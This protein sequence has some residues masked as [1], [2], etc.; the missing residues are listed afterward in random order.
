MSNLLLDNSRGTTGGYGS[1][2]TG[3]S[4]GYDSTGTGLGS[5]GHSTA[6][7]H[8]SNLGNKADPRVDSDRGK[9]LKLSHL[10]CVHA[11][12]SQMDAAVSVVTVWVE[13]VILPAPPVLALVVVMAQPQHPP[14]DHTLRTWVIRPILA[15]TAIEVSW[16]EQ[17]MNMFQR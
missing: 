9:L 11:D 3:H 4:G 15:S 6:G 2:G 10:S 17:D 16:W 8:S 7:P 14:L 1:S 12:L 5:T 13:Q